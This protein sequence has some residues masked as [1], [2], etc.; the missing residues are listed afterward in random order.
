MAMQAE[1]W[2]HNRCFFQSMLNRFEINIFDMPCK[3]N[4]IPNLMFPEI[5]LPNP[6]YTFAVKKN[7]APFAWRA[8]HRQVC[9]IALFSR[10][11]ILNCWVFE[12]PH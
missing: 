1:I 9:D 8:S 12:K 6:L 4:L 7:V 11:A 3:I 2:L 10:Y 5:P